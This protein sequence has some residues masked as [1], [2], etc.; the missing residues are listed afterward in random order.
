MDQAKLNFFKSIKDTALYSAAEKG[1]W[2]IVQWLLAYNS[3][4]FFNPGEIEQVDGV[5]KKWNMILTQDEFAAFCD[6]TR[7]YD[8]VLETL[9]L[10]TTKHIITSKILT[11]VGK[12]L[13]MINIIC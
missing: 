11:M 4:V 2:E 9:C 1:R 12:I 13:N 5:I 8:K 6:Q 3:V 7:H 10:K